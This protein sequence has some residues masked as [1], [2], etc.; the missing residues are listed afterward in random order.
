[1]GY[2][3][4][5][6][7]KPAAVEKAETTWNRAQRYHRR[8]L[9]LQKRLADQPLGPKP[10]GDSPDSEWQRYWTV[11]RRHDLIPHRVA[12]AGALSQ[13]L[14]GRLYAMYD[15]TGAYFRLNIWG[16]RECREIMYELGMLTTD[17]PSVDNLVEYDTG[18]LIPAYKL[19]S[20]DGWL[21]SPA[22]CLNSIAAWERSSKQHRDA[23]FFPR[24]VAFLEKA[25]KLGGF[26]VY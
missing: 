24:W 16:M 9:K 3:M 20:N 18:G 2:D 14:V 26:R 6:K 23:D 17:E 12:L 15:R 10:N 19:C 7:I 11:S 13:S 22:E 5:T 21:V 1:M 4:Y 8:L 25:A